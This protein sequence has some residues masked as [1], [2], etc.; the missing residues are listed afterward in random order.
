MFRDDR[1]LRQPDTQVS[2]VLYL[3][4]DGNHLSHGWWA[5]AD[6]KLESVFPDALGHMFCFF[7]L[8][9][10]GSTRLHKRSMSYK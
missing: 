1:R 7:D 4:A 10:A 2:S 3:L 9:I 6:E 8:D 5:L